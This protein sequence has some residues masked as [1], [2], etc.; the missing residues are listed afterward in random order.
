[1]INGDERMQLDSLTAALRQMAALFL[2]A[3]LTTG[4][5]AQESPTLP[6]APSNAKESSAPSQPEAV[7][8][9]TKGRGHFPNPIG[10][11]MGRDVPPPK[12][13]NT[14]RIDQLLRDGK[15]YLSM[16]D[17]VALAL[18]NNLDIAIQRYNLNIADTDIL[19]AKS[20]SS[21]LGVNSGLVLG[22]PGGGQGGL[23]GQVGSGNGG[24]TAGIG[25]VG[26]G[27]G[28]LVVSTLGSGPQI[29]SFD[30]IIT[31][32]AQVDHLINQCSNFF[33]GTVQNTTTAN[34]AYNQGFMTGTNMSVG[35]NNTRV[36][37]NNP[38]STI[39]P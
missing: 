2:A 7:V 37:G 31:G 5:W 33:C 6:N 19:R 3:T 29:T 10:P 22:T 14:A 26:T 23:S 9:Y 11:Y 27:T 34:F 18:E 20:G 8:D 36:A 17:A 21:I 13:A 15:L 38:I 28:G 39:N 1:M 25:G 32:T 16:N 4:T 35:F 12:L 30:P 24:T